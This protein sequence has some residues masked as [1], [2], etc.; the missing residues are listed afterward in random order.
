MYALHDLTEKIT[1]FL[2]KTIG[3][4][5]NAPA[6]VKRRFLM[7]II[8]LEAQQL[9]ARLQACLEVVIFLLDSLW[10]SSMSEASSLR[11]DSK[12][13]VVCLEVVIF[14]LDSL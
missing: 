2:K 8:D 13:L 14:L 9:Q 1:T 7:E 3:F 4:G 11:P 5:H 10:K 12:D 6:G